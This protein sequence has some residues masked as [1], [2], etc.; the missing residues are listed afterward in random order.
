MYSDYMEFVL[1]N[2]SLVDR[3]QLGHSLFKREF[4]TLGTQVNPDNL[5]FVFQRQHFPVR[6]ENKALSE[7]PRSKPG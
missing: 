6:A 7:N 1:Y 5:L 2:F 3:F 4:R